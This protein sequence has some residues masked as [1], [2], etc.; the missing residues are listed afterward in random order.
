MISLWPVFII[1]VW[2]WCFLNFDSS[3][4]ILVPVAFKFAWY[5]FTAETMYEFWKSPYIIYDIHFTHTSLIQF[6]FS[7][8]N[9]LIPQFHVSGVTIWLYSM[10]LEM[11]SFY[12]IGSSSFRSSVTSWFC[13]LSFDRHKITNFWVSNSTVVSLLKM[14]TVFL[15][16]YTSILIIKWCS[17]R[18]AALSA[19]RAT[20]KGTAR[21]E[22]E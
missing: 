15:R 7:S 19:R 21:W 16:N 12:N 10:L 4:F 14:W 17:Q 3:S 9:Y 2:G 5:H 8:L 18:F 20:S 11:C 6:K 13:M 1:A 22:R